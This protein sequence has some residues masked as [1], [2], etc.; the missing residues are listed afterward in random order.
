MKP[1]S[2]KNN[3][4]NKYVGYGKCPICGSKGIMRERRINGN[5]RCEKGHVY[6]SR[7]SIK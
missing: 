5:D 6:P 2:D 1:T 7:S 4:D 3:K